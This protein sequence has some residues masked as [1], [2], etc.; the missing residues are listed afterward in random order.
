MTVNPAYKY[1]DCF[2]GGITWYMMNTHDFISSINFE[3]KNEIGELVSFNAQSV[4][5]SLSIKE[6]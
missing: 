2:A 6:V 4:T 1:V 5:F 3:I